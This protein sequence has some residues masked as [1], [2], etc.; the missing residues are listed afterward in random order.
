MQQSKIP[1]PGYDEQSMGETRRRAGA[2][3]ITPYRDGPYIVRGDFAVLGQDGEPIET[4]RRTIALC[5]CGKSQLRPFCDG[6][7]KLIG[8]EAAGTDEREE[9]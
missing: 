2:A 5:R 6:T 7:H 3:M 9:A 4:H 8:F 1:K